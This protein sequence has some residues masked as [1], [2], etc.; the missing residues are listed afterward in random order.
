MIKGRF[1]AVGLLFLSTASRAGACDLCAVYRASDAD[2]ANGASFVVSIAE[3]FIPHRNSRFN[4]QEVTPAFD[5]YVDSSITHFVAGYNFSSRWGISLNVPVSYLRF[6]RQDLRYSLNAPPVV[7]VEN[8]HEFGLGDVSLIGR[9]GLIELTQMEW[10][11]V[12]NALAG[13]KFPTG[14]DDRLQ[15]EIAQT[16]IFESFLPPGTPHDPLSHSITGVHQH[17]VA[18]GSG[19]FDGIFG[20]TLNGRWDRWFVN[21]QFQYYLRT[22][23]ESGY[24]RGDELMLSGGPGMFLLLDKNYTLSVQVNALYNWMGRDE[25]LGKRSNLTGSKVWYLGPLLNF[26]WR[27][28]LSANAGVEFPLHFENRGYQVLPNYRLH[29]GLTWRF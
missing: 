15:D 2:G 24:R 11:L 21:G 13:V 27:S 10:A 23:G 7:Y 1:I 20:L 5:E 19:S 25:I 17:Q 18:L 22:E 14:D 9:V 29:G 3:Q 12:V 16:Q 4:G 28:D 26:T 6:Q 8:D